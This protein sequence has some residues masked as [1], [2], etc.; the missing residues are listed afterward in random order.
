MFKNGKK[1]GKRES[2]IDFAVYSN[3]ARNFTDVSNSVDKK[4]VALQVN[5]KFFSGWVIYVYAPKKGKVD[6]VEDEFDT[7]LEPIFDY[8]HITF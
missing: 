8:G 4:I 1:S 6:S 7:G 5:T 3:F 2:T